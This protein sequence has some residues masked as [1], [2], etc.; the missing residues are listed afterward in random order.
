M[1]KY[2]ESALYPIRNKDLLKKHNTYQTP[3]GNKNPCEK[4]LK[5]PLGVGYMCW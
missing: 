1:L 5:N 4:P 2:G 3:K